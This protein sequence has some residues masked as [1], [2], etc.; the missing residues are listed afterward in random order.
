VSPGTLYVVSTPIG[1]LKDISFRALEILDQ[2]DLIAAEDT[3]HTDIL[4]KRHDIAKRMVSYHDHNE[5][6]RAPQLVEFLEAGDSIAL[7]SN[8][9][10]PT[11]SD[12]GYR[13]IK[14]AAE[15]GIPVVP[16]PGSSAVLAA[17]V[18]SGLPT[19]RFLFEGFLPRKKGRTSRLQSLAAFEGTVVIY[20]SPQRIAD[21][22]DDIIAHFGNRQMVLCREITKKFETI[23]RGTVSDIIT[24][25]AVRPLKGECVMVI[26]K[27]GLS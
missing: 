3:R 26:G 15:R 18:M 22:L 27:G 16:I 17:L 24:S 12:P 11:I 9:G 2:V 5:V 8:A 20:E 10:T 13:V 25:V 14:L 4:L 21:T 1:N 19:D 23:L 7:V 6:N